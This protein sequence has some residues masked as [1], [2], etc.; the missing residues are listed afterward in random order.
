MAKPD[1]TNK[2]DVARW[3]GGITLGLNGPVADNLNTKP[4]FATADHR[5]F[6]AAAFNQATAYAIDKLTG[7]H[8]QCC[9]AADDLKGIDTGSALVTLLES[10]LVPKKTALPAKMKFWFVKGSKA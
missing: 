3:A 5:I 8:W 10:H 9:L 4:Y 6:Y 2:E 7:F 1:P